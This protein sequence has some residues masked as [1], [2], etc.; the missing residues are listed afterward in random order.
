MELNN[1]PVLVNICQ[2]FKLNIGGFKLR[3]GEFCK[4]KVHGCPKLMSIRSAIARCTEEV[5]TE[6]SNVETSSNVNE[7]KGTMLISRAEKLWLQEDLMNLISVW[8]GPTFIKFQNLVQL[9]VIKCRR[10]KC[11]FQSTV[12]RSLPC[13]RRLWISECEELEEIMSSGEEEHNHFPNESSNNSFCF[14][15]LCRLK[16]KRCRKLKCIFPSL[17]STQHLPVLYELKIEECSQLKGL[18]NS[19]VEIHEEGFYNNSLPKLRNV[20]VKDCPMFSETTLAALESCQ[21]RHEEEFH[22]NMLLLC[23]RKSQKLPVLAKVDRAS[24]LASEI[25]DELEDVPCENVRQYYPTAYGIQKFPNFEKHVDKCGINISST[26]DD[27]I[28]PACVA[29]LEPTVLLSNFTHNN[30]YASYLNNSLYTGVGLGSEDDWMVLVLTT[31][32]PLALSLPL[33]L[34]SF[35]LFL[36][37]CSPSSPLLLFCL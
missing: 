16:V 18:C 12:M 2:G 28:L 34:I 9:Y 6:D 10:L 3:V 19:E 36:L 13:L 26:S 37:S 24:C 4:V 7:E 5:S 27:V 33:M 11:I 21:R 32:T 22:A 17:P 31:N 8:E 14:P 20:R 29:K 15:L 1:L 35:L 23:Y 25:A 30:P